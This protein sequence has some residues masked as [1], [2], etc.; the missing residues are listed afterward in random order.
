MHDLRLR[1]SELTLELDG[2]RT[3]KTELR[4]KIDAAEGTSKTFEAEN[5]KLI[6]KLQAC[7][8]DN[9]ELHGIIGKSNSQLHTEREKSDELERQLHSANEE[10]SSWQQ[11]S[12]AKNAEME[13]KDAEMEAKDADIALLL[14]LTVEFKKVHKMLN[15]RQSKFPT[16]N[17][18]DAS[19]SNPTPLEDTVKEISGGLPE[20]P[21]PAFPEPST[22]V[23]DESLSMAVSQSGTSSQGSPVPLPQSRDYGKDKAAATM[24]RAAKDGRSAPG[25]EDLQDRQLSKTNQT[26]PTPTPTGT[27][28]STPSRGSGS[29][30]HLHLSLTQTSPLPPAAPKTLLSLDKLPSFQKKPEAV[31]S[32][33]AAP[34]ASGSSGDPRKR[35]DSQ[36]IVDVRQNPQKRQARQ[37]F[38]LPSRWG[39]KV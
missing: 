38:I 4:S 37:Q 32:P 30:P 27:T 6:A 10:I 17:S 8:K 9:V 14:D 21:Q 25:P 16:S 31:S 22:E 39:R 5:K 23:H 12:K 26:H 29:T 33:R 35:Q 1:N 15:S 7:N 20:G 2:K 36:A 34:A 3:T 18:L 13:A 24:M 11:T 28:S 19:V